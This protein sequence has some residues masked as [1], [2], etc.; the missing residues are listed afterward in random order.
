MASLLFS[1][2]G[3]KQALH[4][5]HLHS[6]AIQIIAVAVVLLLSALMLLSVNV[7]ALQKSFN[8]VQQSDQVLLSLSEVELRLQGNELAVRG[9][10]LTDDPVF[11]TYQDNE[12][13]MLWQ[14]MDKLASE[15]RDEPDNR[16]RYL[17]LREI[18][19]KR[20]YTLAYLVGIGPRNTKEV[21]DAIRTAAYRAVM[22]ETRAQIAAFRADEL[23]VLNAR[24]AMA[25]GQ[26][27]HTYEFAIAIVVLA[28]VFAALGIAFAMFGRARAAPRA[29]L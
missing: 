6:F 19:K 12:V 26:A 5:G 18:V 15:V 2:R 10:A 3:L 4:H 11:V 8:W 13:R 20:L 9:F 24:Q 27:E 14:A 1:Q 25:A 29:P 16:A 28:F 21:A 23:K 17:R 22:R 7:T